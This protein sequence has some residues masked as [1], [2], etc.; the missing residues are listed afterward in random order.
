M[1]RV[2]INGA[3]FM[4]MARGEKVTHDAIWN[5]ALEPSNRYVLW[6]R[7]ESWDMRFKNLDNRNLEWLPIADNLLGSENDA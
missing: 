2:S 7:G 3:L 6:P 5:E 4:F 1:R